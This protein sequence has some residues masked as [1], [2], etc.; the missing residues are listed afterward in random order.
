M[1]RGLNTKVKALPNVP[2]IDDYDVQTIKFSS[3]E[4]LRIPE[5]SIGLG[6]LTITKFGTGWVISGHE[7]E[8]DPCPTTTPTRT[9]T[10]IPTTT[11]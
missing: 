5:G 3:C 11:R 10:T 9:P 8:P 1:V 7:R 4:S 2:L 6:K